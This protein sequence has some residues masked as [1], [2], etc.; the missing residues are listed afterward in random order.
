MLKMNGLNKHP[1]F[2]RPLS[3]YPYWYSNVQSQIMWMFDPWNIDFSEA[4]NEL[5]RLVLYGG[6]FKKGGCTK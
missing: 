3:I 4:M 5:D 1:Y 6:K 2:L